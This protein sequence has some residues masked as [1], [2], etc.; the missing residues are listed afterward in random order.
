MGERELL[1]LVWESP[2]NLSARVGRLEGKSGQAHE[3]GLARDNLAINLSEETKGSVS[4][5]SGRCI[6]MEPISGDDV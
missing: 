3:D 2:Q 6:S 4:G 5:P 1:G